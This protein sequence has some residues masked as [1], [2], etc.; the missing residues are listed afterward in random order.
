MDIEEVKRLVELNINDAPEEYEGIEKVQC[1]IK[2]VWRTVAGD[3]VI[4]KI[5]E[6]F[7]PIYCV[8]KESTDENMVSNKICR[9][10]KHRLN[11]LKN[12]I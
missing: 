12:K 2:I 11:D 4:F 1:S 9:N 10:L 3:V 5:K 6:H 8:I 7:A